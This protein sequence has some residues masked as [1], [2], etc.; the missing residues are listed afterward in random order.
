MVAF[1]FGQSGGIVRR[2]TPSAV[3]DVRP[4]AEGRPHPLLV[5]F[6]SRLEKLGL[7]NFKDKGNETQHEIESCKG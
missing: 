4:S 2:I 1:F 6:L 7:A 5:A 3:E